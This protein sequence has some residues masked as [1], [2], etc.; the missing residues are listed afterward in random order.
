MNEPVRPF[1]EEI[2]EYLSEKLQEDL[3]DDQME[4]MDRKLEVLRKHSE[5]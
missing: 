3:S 5:D 1:K 2:R 4:R